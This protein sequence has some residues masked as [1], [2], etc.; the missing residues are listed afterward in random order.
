MSREILLRYASFTEGDPAPLSALI[1][2]VFLE[3]E[4]P[5]YSEEGIQTFKDFIEPERLAKQIREKQMRFYCCYENDSPVGVLAYRDASHISL[6]FV[7]KAFHGQGI[8]REL[9]TVSLKD[10]L[11]KEQSVTEITVHSS[12]Y[13][14]SISQKLGFAAQ[15]SMQ[16]ENGLKYI[17]M[18]KAISGRERSIR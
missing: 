6:L 2:K 14:E 7:E 16:I 3:F 13:A 18:K 15:D 1:W 12:P 17:P 10:I 4:A 5:E 9:L 8:A 11:E